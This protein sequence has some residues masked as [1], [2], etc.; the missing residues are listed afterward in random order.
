MPRLLLSGKEP[1]GSIVQEV[2][3]TPEPVCTTWKRENSWPY[4]DSNSLL[5]TDMNARYIST[6]IFNC[7]GFCYIHY[8]F[9]WVQNINIR[10]RQGW[11]PFF[12]TSKRCCNTIYF[13]S[14]AI[15]PFGPWLLFQFLNPIYTVG[16]IPWMGNQPVANPLP[17]YRTT[18]PQN[19][20]TEISV[21]RTHDP[22]VRAG[23]DGSCLY[24]ATTW[25]AVTRYTA[26]NNGQ[27]SMICQ[28]TLLATCY[29]LVSCLAYSSTMKMKATRFLRNVGWLS[30]DYTVL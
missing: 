10:W 3:W 4:R 14:M 27:R 25:S 22:T 20:R 28:R 18:Q 6:V 29:T 30:T 12:Y 24:R 23:E 7:T 21:P 15:Q 1:P 17:T 11:R 13:L 16:R 8:W 9:K 2:G 19:K 5:M 26:P